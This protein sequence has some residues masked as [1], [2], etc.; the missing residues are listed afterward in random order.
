MQ[1]VK[2]I[3][4]AGLRSIFK[5]KFKVITDSTDKFS[6]SGN[7]LYRD[8]KP[9]TLGSMGSGNHLHQNAAGMVIFNHC[10]R[11]RDKN[12]IGWALSETVKAIDINSAKN[13]NVLPE[14]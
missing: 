13:H 5:R 4:K 7:I 10:N 3:R 8:F 9:G 2:P 11:S 6:V 14:I 1:V 12:V